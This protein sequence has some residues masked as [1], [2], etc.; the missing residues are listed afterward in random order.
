MSSMSSCGISGFTSFY[1]FLLR[2][3]GQRDVTCFSASASRLCSH[4]S[5]PCSNLQKNTSVLLPSLRLQ[6]ASLLKHCV[7]HSFLQPPTA[8][9]LLP[10]T[11]V[12]EIGLSGTDVP[13]CEHRHRSALNWIYTHR[14]ALN[15]QAP[16]C[17]SCI[18]R[19]RRAS[20]LINRHQDALSLINRR[21][22]QCGIN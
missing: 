14:C 20:N 19:H 16:K 5:S 7:T 2:H 22:H 6:L 21:R 10:G 18:I 4:V 9:N 15:W 13:T 8:N 1:F 12:Y 3:C 17:L 11:D